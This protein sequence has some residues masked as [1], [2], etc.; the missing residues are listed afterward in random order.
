MLHFRCASVLVGTM[1][2]EKFVS[3]FIR[4]DRKSNAN[5]YFFALVFKSYRQT[6]GTVGTRD[7]ATYRASWLQSKTSLAAFVVPSSW[8]SNRMTR[9]FLCDIFWRT[10]A[11]ALA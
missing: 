6:L 11:K 3:D 5:S 10:L 1:L 4:R 2:L 7:R 9:F 8:E